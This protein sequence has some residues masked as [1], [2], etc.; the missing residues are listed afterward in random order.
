[1]AKAQKEIRIQNRKARFQYEFSDKFVAGIVLQG[2]EIK[3]I[4]EGKASIAESYCYM[5]KGELFVRQ[6]NIQEYS[7]GNINNHEPLRVRKLLLSK[8]ELAKLEGKMKDVG[9]AVIP[10]LLFINEKGLAKL[11]IGLGR[12][13]KLHDKRQSIKEREVKRDLDRRLR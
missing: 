2:T 3:A 13:K 11:E 7:H 4:R 12:G 10:L 6:M 5:D 1:M 8:R 9:N